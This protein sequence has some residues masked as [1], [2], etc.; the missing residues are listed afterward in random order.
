MLN[1][2]LDQHMLEH[3]NKYGCYSCVMSLLVVDVCRMSRK[4]SHNQVW[5]FQT[6]RSYH[7]TWFADTDISQQGHCLYTP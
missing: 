7:I 6:F 2:M 4:V 5:T 1:T 3:M